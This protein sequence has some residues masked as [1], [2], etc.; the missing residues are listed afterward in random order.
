MQWQ[1][2]SQFLNLQKL[3]IV[4]KD[5]LQKVSQNS[6]KLLMQKKLQNGTNEANIWTDDMPSHIK[7]TLE[8]VNTKVEEL[9]N[10]FN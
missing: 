4:L 10:E 6:T 5:Q 8:D 3:T 2:E 1:T 7:E 9:K